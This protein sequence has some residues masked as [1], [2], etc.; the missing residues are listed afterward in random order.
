MVS[1]AFK[2]HSNLLNKSEFV[3]S[4]AELSEGVV[5]FPLNL[6]TLET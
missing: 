3:L 4:K 2:C 1:Y 6:C 5:A